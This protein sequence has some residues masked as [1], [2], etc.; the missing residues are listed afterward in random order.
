MLQKNKN[1]KAFEGKKKRC[2]RRRKKGRKKEIWKN[3]ERSL[4][5][6]KKEK[7]LREN[8]SKK[9]KPSRLGLQKIPTAFPQGVK[10]E[11]L[12][13]DVKQFDC[14]ALAMLELW[15]MRSTP[16]LPSL[17]VPLYPGVVAPERVL[18]MGQIEHLTFKLR[19]I[20][21]L[22]LKWIVKNKTFWSFNRV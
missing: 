3:K 17:Q 7:E 4:K 8:E 11:C 13:Y 19:A 1:R 15:G 22:M 16:S 18:F 21:W 12:V 10:N 2:I 14:E 20:K 5:K 9:W 6:A